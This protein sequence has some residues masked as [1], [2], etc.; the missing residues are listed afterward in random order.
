MK[1]GVIGFGHLGKALVK[2]IFNRDIETADNIYVCARSESTL[3]I[4]S[5]EFGV[6]TTNDINKIFEI[7]DLVFLV[8]KSDVFLKTEFDKAVSDDK[9][10]VSFIA[11]VTIAQ[12]KEK[13]GYDAEIIRAMPTLSMENGNGIIGYTKTTNKTIAN[14]FEKLGYA[15]AVDEDKIDVVT[16]FSA[17]GLGFAAYII[18]AFKQVGTQM[19]FDEDTSRKIVEDNFLSA[20]NS[21]DYNKTIQEVATKGGATEQ[22]ILYFEENKLKD[23]ISGAIMEAEIKCKN[24]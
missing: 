6:N 21:K 22:G 9:T 20:I 18:E 23:I 10:V 1:I 24:K 12:I 15:F 16:A 8:L 13:L 3:K 14:I 17:C 7:A 2:G 5:E 19:G 4:A 11:G